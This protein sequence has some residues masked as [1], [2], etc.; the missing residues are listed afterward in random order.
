MHINNVSQK[1]SMQ[2]ITGFL[3][4]SIIYTGVMSAMYFSISGGDW[5]ISHFW[6]WVITSYNSLL[7][8]NP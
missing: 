6:N 4:V 2:V 7:A 1:T 8:D 5:S 3:F